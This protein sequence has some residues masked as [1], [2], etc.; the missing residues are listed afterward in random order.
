MIAALGGLE[1]GHD[2][3]RVVGTEL[4]VADATGPGTYGGGCGGE[5]DG[6]EARWVVGADRGGDHVEEGGAG[7]PDAEGALGA[8]HGWAQVEGVAAGAGGFM[9]FLLVVGFSFLVGMGWKWK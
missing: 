5:G 3:R 4:A 7:G 8:D 9:G 1:L 2:T 6:A